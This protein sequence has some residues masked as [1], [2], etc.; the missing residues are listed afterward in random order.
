MTEVLISDIKVNRTTPVDPDDVAA[1]AK[2]LAD[3][4]MSPLIIDWHG[5][6]L[7]GLLRLRALETLG[8]TKADVY[9]AET[10]EQALDL[11]KGFNIK[12]V[13]PR[14]TY[15]LV[16]SLDRL[17]KERATRVHGLANKRR[18]FHDAHPAG[19]IP[20]RQLV[21]KTLGASWDRLR[22]VY[23][24]SLEDPNDP[25][26]AKTIAQ[27]D[28][29]TLSFLKVFYQLSQRTE[30]NVLKRQ[31]PL[32]G[33]AKP[34]GV[35]VGDITRPPEQLHLL[36]E[37]DRQLSGSTKAAQRLGFPLQI[38]RAQ[39]LELLGSIM[40]HRRRLTVFIKTLRK[41]LEDPR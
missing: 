38:D 41:E 6:L 32:L 36:V 28:A 20:T 11:L 24:W 27:V 3:R 14:R 19:P 22:R 8:V 33:R 4:P 5:N 35:E 25:L 30:K 9:V 16:E 17:L 21:A 34:G 1:L 10:L 12:T 2:I 18:H 39:A 15:D 13:G 31:D 29:G 37:L 23:R 26:R 40:E 7:D